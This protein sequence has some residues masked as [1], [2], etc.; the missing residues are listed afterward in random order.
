MGGHVVVAIRALA[1]ENGTVLDKGRNNGDGHEN[2]ER[3][4][5]V[6]QADDILSRVGGGLARR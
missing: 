3:G 1:D 4:S 2:K 6:E 5:V